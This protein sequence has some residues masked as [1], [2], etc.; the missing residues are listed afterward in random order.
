MTPDWDK[1]GRDLCTLCFQRMAFNS[2]PLGLFY[3]KYQDRSM[4]RYGRWI[5]AAV[6][7]RP[8]K[9]AINFQS[10]LKLCHLRYIVRGPCLD[11]EVKPSG[12]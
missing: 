11:G 2:V 10:C 7:S 12:L 8:R 9:L 4:L 5:T 1:G 6:G 3:G